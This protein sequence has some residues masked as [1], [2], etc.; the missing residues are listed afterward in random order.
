MHIREKIMECKYYIIFLT[1]CY[2]PHFFQQFI[3]KIK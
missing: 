3:A 2:I 1:L